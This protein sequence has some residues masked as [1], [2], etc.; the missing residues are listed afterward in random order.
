[1]PILTLS[2]V[3]LSIA[4]YAATGNYTFAGIG[5]CI[6]AASL[7][8]RGK[9]KEAFGIAAI[10]GLLIG[11]AATQNMAIGVLLVYFIIIVPLTLKL[12]EKKT[13]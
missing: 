7:A 2:I 1:M 5:V 3:A 12:G 11:N 6:L 10:S 13:A 8:L 9:Y 4:A